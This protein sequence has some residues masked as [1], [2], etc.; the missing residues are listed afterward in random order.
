MSR[1][2]RFSE[3]RTKVTDSLREGPRAVCVVLLCNGNRPCFFEVR[4]EADETFVTLKVRTE[5]VFFSVKY[6][7]RPKIHTTQLFNL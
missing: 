5:T 6:K 4:A 1:I 2:F 7:L 3:G